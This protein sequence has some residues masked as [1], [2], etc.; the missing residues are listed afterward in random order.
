MSD[1]NDELLKGIAAAL[2]KSGKPEPQD[3]PPAP[4]PP[5]PADDFKERLAAA[6]RAANNM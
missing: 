1:N 5:A 4:E 2:A 3:E 6:E